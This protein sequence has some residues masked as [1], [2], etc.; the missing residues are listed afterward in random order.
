MATWEPHL[1]VGEKRLW[2]DVDVKRLC[3]LEFPH[4]RILDDGEDELCSLSSR[5]LVGAVVGVL[6]FVSHFSA[7]ADDGLG[8][9]IDRR[10]ICA[11]S[12]GFGEFRSIVRCVRCHRPNEANEVVCASCLLVRDLEEERRH[13][14]PDSREVD[15]GNMA[16]FPLELFECIGR[17]RPR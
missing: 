4:P 16:V 3:V 6:G 9:A 12:C 5:C 10:V 1:K 8:I 2:R 11:N 17:P 15:V 13:D 14:L 7:C